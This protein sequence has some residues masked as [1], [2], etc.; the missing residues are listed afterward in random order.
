MDKDI[1]VKKGHFLIQFYE[2]KNISIV[3]FGTIFL[4]DMELKFRY[5]R[6]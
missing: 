3:W 6:G 5:F 1:V 2:L 4:K